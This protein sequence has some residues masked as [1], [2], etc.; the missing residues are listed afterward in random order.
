M[1]KRGISDKGG[2]GRTKECNN[3]CL[4]F[5]CFCCCYSFPVRLM[6]LQDMLNGDLASGSTV[7]ILVAKILNNNN[8]PARNYLQLGSYTTA[9]FCRDWEVV[10]VLPEGFSRC[11]P[12]PILPLSYVML[13]SILPAF[14]LVLGMHLSAD[15]KCENM[16]TSRY[17]TCKNANICPGNMLFYERDLTY[18]K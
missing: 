16:I 2:E 15:W 18:L 6:S 13:T 14:L 5:P 1:R 9:Y 11:V 4:Q 17:F 10:G 7:E 8:A 3:K 12:V